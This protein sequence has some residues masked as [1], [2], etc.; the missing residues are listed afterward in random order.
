MT[1]VAVL[2]LDAPFLL[3]ALAAADATSSRPPFLAATTSSDPVLV[4]DSRTT[5]C[6]WS[7]APAAPGFA[8]PCNRRERRAEKARSRVRRSPGCPA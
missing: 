7:R 6:S 3:G 5:A 8:A 2:G 1:R 4:V